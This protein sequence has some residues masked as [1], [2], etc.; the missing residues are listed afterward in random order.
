VNCQNYPVSSIPVELKKDASAVIRIQTTEYTVL[1]TGKA[2]QKTH[3]VITVLSNQG[4]DFAQFAESYDKFSKITDLSGKIYNGEGKVI[5]KIKSSDFIDNKM[6]SSSL[7]DDNRVKVYQPLISDYPYTIEYEWT[8]VLSGIFNYP[9][10]VPQIGYD[11]SVQNS[12]YKISVPKKLPIHF[13]KLN[14]KLEPEI[15]N[16][17]DYISYT[18]R[19]SDLKAIE[20][21]IMSTGND[22][23]PI[24]YSI[25]SWFKL[26]GYSGSNKD[27]N[28]MGLWNMQLNKQENRLSEKTISDLAEIQKKS[29]NKLELVKNVYEY[30]QSKTRYVSIQLGIGGLKPFDAS[31]VDKFGYGDCKALVNYTQTLL[32]QVGI[33]SYYTRVN[34]GNYANDIIT[35]ETFSQFNHIILCV[36]N[37][38]DT[39]WLECTSQVIP[40]AFQGAFTDNRHVLMITPQGGKLVKTHRYTDFENKLIEVGR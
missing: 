33:E 39:L 38:R 8:E 28:S 3:L 23:V 32:H 18:F 25:P 26:D 7:F 12:I 13:K 24:V 37:D 20:H 30:M 14:W 2:E 4:D 9:R 21:E 11:I 22:V 17:V 35:D 40:F 10:W 34:S 15:I 1:D 27:W 31:V 16:N 6:S 29:G 36:P 19:A 5:R